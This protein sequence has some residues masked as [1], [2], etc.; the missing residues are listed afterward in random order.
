ML[1]LCRHAKLGSINGR[2]GSQGGCMRVVSCGGALGM[3]SSDIFYLCK[4]NV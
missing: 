1:A 3:V 2:E 4:S